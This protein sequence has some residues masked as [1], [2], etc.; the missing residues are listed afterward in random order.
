MKEE[1]IHYPTKLL[2]WCLEKEGSPTRGLSLSLPFSGSISWSFRARRGEA[3]KLPPWKLPRWERR[4]S[5]WPW[6]RRRG[7]WGA[8]NRGES[9]STLRRGRWSCSEGTRTWRGRL[10]PGRSGRTARPSHRLCWWS[11][12]LP[13]RL[14]LSPCASSASPFRSWLKKRK[15]NKE[16]RVGFL[17][18]T[19]DQKHLHQIKP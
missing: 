14:S 16:G 18:T 12:R 6:T 19:I 15:K 10:C 17:P 7:S 5:W 8:L 11:P 9:A 2:T 3:W 4:A 13:S 1:S